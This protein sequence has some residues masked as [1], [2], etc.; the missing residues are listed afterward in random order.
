MCTY[1]VTQ[2]A[3]LTFDPEVFDREDVLHVRYVS[4]AVKLF[5]APVPLVDDRPLRAAGQ[6]QVGFVGD[7]QIL[8]ICVPE[9]W[10]EGLVGVEAIAVP[11]VDGGGASLGAVCYDEEGLSIDAKRLNIIWFADFEDVN[12]L[13]FD[14][15]V[16]RGVTFIDVGATEQL[17][18]N[19]KE[20]VVNDQRFA[21]HCGSAW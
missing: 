4:P 19:D 11:L 20:L 9:P 16:G 6:D 10:M 18:H 14:E 17:S 2:A 12:A 21:D 5:L 8:Y 7:L 13:E 3:A 15:F 1:T